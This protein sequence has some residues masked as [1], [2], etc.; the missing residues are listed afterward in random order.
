M[1][2]QRGCV[3]QRLIPSQW[4]G[5]TSRLTAPS[6]G[7]AWRET[8]WPAAGGVWLGSHRPG[9]VSPDPDHNPD[10]TRAGPYQPCCS[11]WQGQPEALRTHMTNL[12]ETSTEGLP[13]RLPTLRGVGCLEDGCDG[14]HYARGLCKHH[15]RTAYYA[16]NAQ[17]QSLLGKQWKARQRVGHEGPGNRVNGTDAEPS[18]DTVSLSP[19]GSGRRAPVTRRERLPSKPETPPERKGSGLVAGRKNRGPGGT[20]PAG[21]RP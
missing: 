3:S 1:A 8:H 13:P 15:Y 18:A 6:G 10:Q 16:A 17:R 12:P 7:G 19:D 9:A 14:K 21:S 5:A 4:S 20:T 11:S 2:G